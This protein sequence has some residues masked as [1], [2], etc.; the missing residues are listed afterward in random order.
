MLNG[1]RK[2]VNL[3]HVLG[4]NF[5]PS[6]LF[7]FILTLLASSDKCLVEDRLA[8]VIFCYLFPL[9]FRRW[10]LTLVVRCIHGRGSM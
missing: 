10:C 3:F 5:Y 8:Q 6:N 2:E 7:I 9:H 1:S 4:E